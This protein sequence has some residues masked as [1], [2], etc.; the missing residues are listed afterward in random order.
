VFYR[1]K[2]RKL[3]KRSSTTHAS[4]TRSKT[5]PDLLATH[6]KSLGISGQMSIDDWTQAFDCSVDISS[7]HVTLDEAQDFRSFGSDLAITILVKFGLEILDEASEEAKEVSS[8]MDN[9]PAGNHNSV[10]MAQAGARPD[11]AESLR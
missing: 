3:L 1:R 11:A 8:T 6:Q 10:A 7:K 2:K 4:T 9:T 5:L